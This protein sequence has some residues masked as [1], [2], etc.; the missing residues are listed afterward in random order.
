MI[1]L[2]ATDRNVGK[3]TKKSAKNIDNK[4]RHCIT[5]QICRFFLADL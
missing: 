5:G 2:K 4:S 1:N 3:I